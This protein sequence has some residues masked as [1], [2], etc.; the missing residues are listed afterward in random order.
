LRW[1]LC[2]CVRDDSAQLRAHYAKVVD[3]L[4]GLGKDGEHTDPHVIAA[5]DPI[6]FGDH[7]DTALGR[8]MLASE[9]DFTS[10]RSCA[11]R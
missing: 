6:L 9:L 10:G 4:F 1:G 5:C 8:K 7:G 11:R 3:F 2:A